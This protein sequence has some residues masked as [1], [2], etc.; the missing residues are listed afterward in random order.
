MGGE[1]PKSSFD[2]NKA[3]DQAIARS[4]ERAKERAE[5]EKQAEQQAKEGG[6]EQSESAAQEGEANALAAVAANAMAMIQKAMN[7]SYVVHGAETYCSCGIRV[8]H[9]VVPLSHGC[10]IHDIAQLIVSDFKPYTNIQTFGGCTSPENPS[11]QAVAAAITE[12]VNSEPKSFW[13]KVM[14][15]FCKNEVKPDDSLMAQCVGECTPI[16]VSPWSNGKATVRLESIK[17]LLETGKLTCQYGG[18]IKLVSTGQ[19]G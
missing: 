5:A 7:P 8:S 1:A 12:K 4:K 18:E 3:A 15:I 9:V 6:Q 19:P 17:P 14:G 11:V 2:A 16:I 13:D 10:F